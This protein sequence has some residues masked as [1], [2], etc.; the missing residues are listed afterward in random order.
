MGVVETLSGFFVY[1]K[2]NNIF[3]LAIIQNVLSIFTILSTL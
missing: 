2:M 1:I 3:T